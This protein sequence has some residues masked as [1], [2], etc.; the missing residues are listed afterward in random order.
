MFTVLSTGCKDYPYLIV[1]EQNRE[2]LPQGLLIVFA[3]RGEEHWRHHDPDAYYGLISLFPTRGFAARHQQVSAPTDY[4][5]N[6]E[7]GQLQINARIHGKKEAI[8]VLKRLKKNVRLTKQDVDFWWNKTD[9]RMQITALSPQSGNEFTWGFGNR[10]FELP[11]THYTIENPVPENAFLSAKIRR[12]FLWVASRMIYNENQTHILDYFNLSMRLRWEIPYVL[13]SAKPR[14][15]DASLRF[16]NMWAF[17]VQKAEKS[18]CYLV[19]EYKKNPFAFLLI[20]CGTDAAATLPRFL[21][22]FSQALLKKLLTSGLDRECA[23][24]IPGYQGHIDITEQHPEAQFVKICS[25][26]MELITENFSCDEIRYRTMENLLENDASVCDRHFDEALMAH[27]REQES[28][29]T[30]NI[31]LV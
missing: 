29:S 18:Y 31:K 3:N 12:N 28:T 11:I 6:M 7:S 24:D 20:R 9:W 5:F 16:S 23:N 10:A 15:N 17:G 26:R 27:T 13:D 19:L 1:I 4:D 8:V 25:D 2:N 22:L 14:L 30:Q 21:E